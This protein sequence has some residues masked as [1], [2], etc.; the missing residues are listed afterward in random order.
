MFRVMSDIRG[1]DGGTC[2]WRRIIKTLVL[3]PIV[4][5]VCILLSGNMKDP[6]L[7]IMHIV[8]IFVAA[9]I[10]LNLILMMF[11]FWDGVSL[12]DDMI[13]SYKNFSKRTFEYDEFCSV[14]M[15]FGHNQHPARGINGAYIFHKG[16]IRYR[17]FV[18][19]FFAKEKPIYTEDLIPTELKK[20]GP[21]MP[22]TSLEVK[23][24]NILKSYECVFCSHG[25]KDIDLIFNLFQG[26]YYIANSVFGEY[27]NELR[28]YMEGYFINDAR[29]HVLSDKR[30]EFNLLGGYKRGM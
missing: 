21:S 4:M 30:V 27:E 28:Y 26:E 8:I 19:C 6:Q 22:L 16:R 20:V 1:I 13:Q 11:C 3:Y 18:A 15:V 2:S 23:N 29:I 14:V 5:S 24:G 12:T 10:L 17:P 9:A 25:L 7:S